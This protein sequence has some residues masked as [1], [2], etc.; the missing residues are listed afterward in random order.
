MYTPKMKVVKTFRLEWIEVL[1][2]LRNYHVK[3]IFIWKCLCDYFSK[4]EDKRPIGRFLLALAEGLQSSGLREGSSSHWPKM[5]KHST[6][7]VANKVLIFRWARELEGSL[8]LVST[9]CLFI[10]RPLAPVEKKLRKE[11]KQKI[12]N[13]RQK[14]GCKVWKD[15]TYNILK[16]HIL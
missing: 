12:R 10:F 6:W 9:D 1:N 13:F 16:I 5:T 11:C 3:G 4:Q 14:Q 15:T 8:C 2:A 7:R